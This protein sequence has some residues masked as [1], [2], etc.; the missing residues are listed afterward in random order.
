MSKRSLVLDRRL[1]RAIRTFWST[2]AVQALRQGSTGGKKDT[3]ARASVT[4][5]AQMGG[6]AQLMCDMLCENGVPE[7]QVFWRRDAE[8]P[9]WYRPEKQWDLL[10]VADGRLLAVIE[11]KSQIGSFGNNYNNRTEE[12]IGS[13]SDVLAAYREGAF[14]PSARPW[15]G[16]LMLLEEAPGSLRPVRPSEPH[17][18]VFPEFKQASYA[19][20]YEILLTKLV[21]EQLYDSTCLLLSSAK[22][23]ARRGD[24]REPSVELSFA[25]FVSSLLAKAVA[26]AKA[27]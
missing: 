7:A 12:A 19:K 5:G 10:V 15:L 27:K 22:G 20:R 23:G 14:K 2:R 1:R 4:G 18:S 9:G 6:F 13:A 25:N 24:Y 8:I 11:F 21:R 17:F 26:N 16:Y 3:G